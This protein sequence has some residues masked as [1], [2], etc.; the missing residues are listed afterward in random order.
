M[1]TRECYVFGWI[2]GRLARALGD[3]EPTN[4]PVRQSHPFRA[5]GDIMAA[6][7][8]ERVMTPEI[9]REICAAADEINTDGPEIVG[10]TEKFQPIENQ[11]AWSLGYL[12]GKLGSPLPPA[13]FDIAAARKAKKMTQEQ[14]AEAMGVD[15]AVVSRWETGTNKPQEANLNKLKDI[16]L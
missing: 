13:T 7:H 2:Y 11:G 15:R 8:R 4:D 9:D 5:M 10:G 1:T 12:K 16:L 14:L 6:A 3:K